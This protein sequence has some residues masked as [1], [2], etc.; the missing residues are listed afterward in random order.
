MK[1]NKKK[2]VR[3]VLVSDG[4]ATSSACKYTLEQICHVD[5]LKALLLEMKKK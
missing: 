5:D 2:H 1:I 3:T 4:D